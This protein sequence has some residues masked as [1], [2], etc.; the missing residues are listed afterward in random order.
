MT[1]EEL[2]LVLHLSSDLLG[3]HQMRRRKVEFKNPL[4]QLAEETLSSEIQKKK[5]F[6]AWYCIIVSLKIFNI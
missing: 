1:T 4:K 2:L 3:V 5:L 6:Y